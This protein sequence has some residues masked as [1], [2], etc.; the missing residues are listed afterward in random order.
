MPS[1]TD[2]L[3]QLSHQSEQIYNLSQANTRPAGPYT[4]T[5]LH[6]ITSTSPHASILDLIREAAESEV[7]L[8]KFIGQTPEYEK[9]VEKRDGLV[10][11]LK[12]LKHGRARG[13][14]GGAGEVEVLLT[15]AGKLVDD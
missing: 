9:K 6:P 5:Y 11:P 15:T 7:R 8:F 1:L 4:Q 3:A 13:N 12:E 10:T 14:G 2:S